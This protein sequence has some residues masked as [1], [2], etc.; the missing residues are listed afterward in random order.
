HG[1]VPWLLAW[2]L[3]FN[4][5]LTDKFSLKAAPVIYYYA[6]HGAS[7]ANQ[8]NNPTPSFDGTFVGQGTSVGVL[9]SAYYNL[10]NGQSVGAADGFFSNETGTRN[11]TVLDI[12]VEM[13]YKWDK[14]HLR[15]FGD[16]AQN[17]DGGERAQ[18]AYEASQNTILFPTSSGIFR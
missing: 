3:G 11:L 17:L 16:Y 10:A 5:H 13:V 12:P 8:F 14:I 2:Q 18:K 4:Y 7:A 6:G 1:N 15:V 9:G